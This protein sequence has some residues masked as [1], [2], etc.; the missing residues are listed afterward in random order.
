MNHWWGSGA[1]VTINFLDFLV[2]GFTDVDGSLSSLVDKEEKLCFLPSLDWEPLCVSLIFPNC[3][4]L[5]VCDGCPKPYVGILKELAYG[6]D[7]L[8][9]IEFTG[10]MWSSSSD[11]YFGGLQL[12]PI[13]VF[14]PP[15][16]GI[17]LPGI[18]ICM[19]IFSKSAIEGLLRWDEWR[20]L[21]GD[22]VFWYD[23]RL[24]FR[25]NSALR[26]T[27]SVSLAWYSVISSA[28]FCASKSSSVWQV[29]L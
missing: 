13:I 28:N 23:V 4:P 6:I 12:F 5:N 20:L 15:K 16:L 22:H 18:A 25:N 29:L 17:R 27:W 3:V 24:I 21:T 26:S 11:R 2:G 10:K 14:D 9:A 7:D 19:Q 1:G 8:L